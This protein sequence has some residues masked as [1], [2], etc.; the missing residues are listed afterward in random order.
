LSHENK[1]ISAD[2]YNQ[3]NAAGYIKTRTISQAFDPEKQ[4]FLPDFTLY[5]WYL[6]AKIRC[7]TRNIPLFQALFKPLGKLVTNLIDG[8]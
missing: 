2:I 5:T 7:I 6:K 8:V 3:L 1:T 4:M